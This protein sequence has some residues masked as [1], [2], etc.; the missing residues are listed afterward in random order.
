MTA[1]PIDLRLAEL[2]TRI[3]F[4]DDLLA[5]MNQVVALQDQR[6]LQ[7][8]GEVRRLR[9][10]LG[11]MRVTVMHDAADEPPPPHY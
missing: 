7:L 4:M 8:Q 3:A 10:D 9:E 2:E 5:S 11:S 6:L 1:D